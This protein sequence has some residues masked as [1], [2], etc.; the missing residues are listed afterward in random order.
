MLGAFVCREIALTAGDD[1]CGRDSCPDPAAEYVGR[2]LQ[3]ERESLYRERLCVCVCGR[4]S[5]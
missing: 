5:E 4:E 1:L 2:H 3:R